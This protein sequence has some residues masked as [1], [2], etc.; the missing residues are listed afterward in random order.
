M[1]NRRKHI[2]AAELLSALNK[3]PQWLKQ[4][5][6]IRAKDKLVEDLLAENERP[7]ITALADIGCNVESV[8]D[9]V[10]SNSSY[11]HAIP[12]LVEHLGKPYYERTR[13]GIVRAL[14][15][16]EARGAVARQLL[17]EL[18]RQPIAQRNLLVLESIE[19]DILP[20]GDVRWALANAMTVVADKSM[21]DEISAL[22]SDIR[23]ADVKERLNKAL[24]S[25]GANPV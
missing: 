14:T 25:L 5:S 8:W 11:S 6:S 16:V 12:V 24:K 20:K 2:T 9:L 4:N 7:I 3:D 22:A 21:V 18:K 17:D 19:T 15:V 23:Y 13:E 10:N 1:T